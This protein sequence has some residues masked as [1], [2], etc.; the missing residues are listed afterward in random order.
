MFQLEHGSVIFRPF[1]NYDR[2]TKQPTTNGE[3]NVMAHREV[4]LNIKQ[5]LRGAIG[6]QGDKSKVGLDRC[7]KHMLNAYTCIA[8]DSEDG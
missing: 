6:A 4:T 5:V 8:G 2:P 3:T 1:G 7:L